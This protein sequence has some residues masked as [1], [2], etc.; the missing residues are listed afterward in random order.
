MQRF[1]AP[2]D[3]GLTPDPIQKVP[4]WSFEARGISLP[5]GHFRGSEA[6]SLLIIE[7]IL[8]SLVSHADPQLE[9]HLMSDL[10]MHA[11]APGIQE[12]AI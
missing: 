1:E 8:R 4:I 3:F 5:R 6:G 2:S 7:F 10:K 11:V 12:A 9:A